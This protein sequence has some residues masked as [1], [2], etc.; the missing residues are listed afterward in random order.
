MKPNAPATSFP[1][2]HQPWPAK[3]RLTTHHGSPDALG[4]HG[5]R[6]IVTLMHDDLNPGERPGPHGK[7][8]GVA[9]VFCTVFMTVPK[10]N[11]SNIVKLMDPTLKFGF[12]SSEGHFFHAEDP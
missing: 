9:W 2:R 12:L 1:H 5:D 6:Y 4:P 3:E 7:S 11:G 8:Q 10:M